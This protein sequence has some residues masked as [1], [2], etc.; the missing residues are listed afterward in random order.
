MSVFGKLASASGI[1]FFELVFFRNAVML[2]LTVPMLWAGHVNPF[3]HRLDGAF[4]LLLLRG[5]LGFLSLSAWYYSLSLLPLS[6]ANALSFL[7]PAFVAVLAPW[8]L[9]EPTPEGVMWSLPLC[10]LGM[11]LVSQPAF[12]FGSAG[13]TSA[14]S[15]L[16]VVVGLLQVGVRGSRPAAA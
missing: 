8:I 13:R 1:G 12:I 11:L 6:D 3:N 15:T 5:I 14:P 2:V 9:K 16:G 7:S 4:G 10:M